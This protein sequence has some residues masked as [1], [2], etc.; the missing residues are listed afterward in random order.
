[1]VDNPHDP[2]VKGSL[3]DKLAAAVVAGLCAVFSFVAS[4]FAVVAFSATG[5]ADRHLGD[6]GSAWLG[7]SVG[8]PLSFIVA[9]VIF[10]MTLRWRLKKSSEI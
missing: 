3:Y 10:V 6:E 4:M 7:I 1:M 9:I 2:V 8:L 5:L